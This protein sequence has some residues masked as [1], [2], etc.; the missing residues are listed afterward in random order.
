MGSD[1]SYEDM[2]NRDINE[3]IYNLLGDEI[4]NDQDYYTLIKSKK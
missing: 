1:L 4:I 3:N 2:S